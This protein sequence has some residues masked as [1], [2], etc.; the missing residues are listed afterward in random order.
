MDMGAAPAAPPP[1]PP[2]L[3]SGS[4]EYPRRPFEPSSIALT[5]SSSLHRRSVRTKVGKEKSAPGCEKGSGRLAPLK[6]VGHGGAGGV[7]QGR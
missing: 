2:S 7:L 1:G 4:S 6:L 3:K 5:M